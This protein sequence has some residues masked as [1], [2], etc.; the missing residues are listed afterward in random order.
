MP[1]HHVCSDYRRYYQVGGMT[2]CVEADLAIT[3]ATFHP[4]FNCFAAAGPGDDTIHIRH[5]F[6][7]PDLEA[8]EMGVNVYRRPPWV[9]YRHDRSWTYLVVS[10]GDHSPRI[11]QAAVFTCDHARADIYHHHEIQAVFK[12]G[13]LASLSLLP[14][15]QI[16]LARI[17][18]DRQ[19]GILHSGGVILE[20]QGLLFVGHS[21]AGKSTLVTLLKE[22]AEILCDD[23]IIIRHQAG[24]CRIYGTWSHGDVPLVSPKSAPLKAILFLRQARDNQ[25][26]RLS[27]RRKIIRGLLACLVKPLATA[28]WWHRMLTLMPL[29][30]TAAPCYILEFDKSGRVVDVL[31][32]MLE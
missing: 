16:I 23:R 32:G 11:R 7:L 4:K 9:I 25:A 28:D 29:I 17:L 22:T 21:D 18:A 8:G 13:G 10:D 5:H 20:K 26:L 27:D 1:M 14:T 12:K 15:D 31:K 6:F 30:A 19:G 2:I 3:D 24:G